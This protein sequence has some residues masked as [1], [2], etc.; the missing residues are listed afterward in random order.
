MSATCRF[1]CF[2]SALA[3]LILSA[4]ALAYD[5]TWYRAD[6]WAGEY[7]NGFTLAEDVTVKIRKEARPAASRDVD[8]ALKKGATY[9]PWN[10]ERVKSDN[11]DFMSYVRKVTYRI[12]SRAKVLLQDEKKE[13]DKEIDF[14]PGD[15]WTWLTYYGEGMFRM[16]L[17]GTEY[18]ADQALFDVS[19]EK[20]DREHEED[21]W[22][23]LTCTNGAQGWLLLAD[24]VDEPAFDHPDFP[25]YG[26]A[27]DRR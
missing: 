20:G 22:L 2:L 5:D 13:A 16:E 10:G 15:T 26:K 9:H 24:V 7:P 17:A 21:E 14:K 8:C 27:P 6:F 11:L 1:A 12:K 3:S 23:K 4:P 25:E 18:A 19:E